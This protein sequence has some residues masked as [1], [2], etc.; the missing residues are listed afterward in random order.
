MVAVV[1]ALQVAAAEV[2]ETVHHEQF[3][4]PLL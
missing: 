2:G 1:A 4:V 3:V